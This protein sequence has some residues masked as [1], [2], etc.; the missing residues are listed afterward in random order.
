MH[1]CSY[2]PILT[3]HPSCVFLLHCL[4]QK[5]LF[6]AHIKWHWPISIAGWCH[7]EVNVCNMFIYFPFH[8]C[9]CLHTPIC[10]I[11]KWQ[12]CLL[13]H[14]VA[15]FVEALHHKLEGHGFNS[16]GVNGIFY[17]HN[18]FGHTVSVGSTQPLTEIITRN[19]SWGVKAASA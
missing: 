17:W 9:L 11:Y 18:P 16:P 4:K 19:I 1:C 8:F 5:C 14:M 6:V 15:H 12:H 2:T 13:G 3:L 10:L 7:T